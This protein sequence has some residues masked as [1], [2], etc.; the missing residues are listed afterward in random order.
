[1]IKLTV[2]DTIVEVDEGST[3]FQ[4][5]E[6]A[7]VEVP[8]F[9]YHP[10]LS[11]AGNC[12]MCLVEVEKSPKPVASCAMPASEGM[13]VKTKTEMV[14]KAREG[15]LELLLINHPLD[16]P[17]CDQG[18]ECDLQD[19]TVS[20]GRGES[21][22]DLNKR[23]VQDKNMGPLIK[24]IMTRCIHCTRCVR[25]AHE[26]A[27]TDELA[28]VNRGE[29][30]EITSL[31]ESAVTSELSGNLVD[32]C[33]VGA[34]TNKPYAFHGR[35]WELTKTPT[36]DVMDGVGS[37]I[38]L[39]TRG[40][41]EVM[42][43]LPRDCDDVNEDWISDRTRF[44]YD[45]LKYQRLDKPYLR[46]KNKLMPATWG[47]AFTSVAHLLSKHKSNE[48]AVLAGPLAD[49]DGL[50]A[51]KKLMQ[52]MGVE[53]FECRTQGSKLVPQTRQ[54]YLFNTTIA[55]IEQADICLLI[56]TNPRVDATL[57]NARLRKQYL[58]NALHVGLVGEAA[59][60][61]YPYV[62]LGDKPVDIE[63]LRDPKHP[64][65]MSLTKASNP[66]IILG[67]AVL[68]HPD[69]D[70]ILALV[71][72]FAVSHGAIRKDWNGFNI[73]H[74]Q[75]GT[76]GALDLG[77]LPKNPEHDIESLYG[78]VEAGR[79]KILYLYG[80]DDIDF[81]RLKKATIIYQGH[82]GDLGAHH[83]HVILPG[84]A[85]SEKTALYVN[86]EGRVQQ[87]VQAVTT[88]GDAKEDWRIVRSL[89][90]YLTKPLPF[91]TH[92]DLLAKL[93]AEYP[94]FRVKGEML[95]NSTYSPKVEARLAKAKLSNR[96]LQNALQDVY[97]TNV[98]ARHSKIL[99]ECSRTKAVSASSKKAVKSAGGKR[100]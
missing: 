9:C 16:C 58:H 37:H 64:M 27:G 67:E 56:G 44:A 28:A 32:I 10:K 57:V 43:V 84:A 63:F 15:V 31:L 68:S 93:M 26:I 14:K 65:T 20:Y 59:D 60:L 34:L 62:H 90:D 99:A 29:H 83:A 4:A 49:V 21:R 66:M 33:P 82:H 78:D 46:D 5:C 86:I 73:L 13:V 6:K 12:R 25:F 87:A 22:F 23:A 76:T 69:A 48:I 1:M 91:D 40:A 30:M 35:P 38:R 52:S 42:R 8:A 54:D 19:I 70:K 92:Y 80:V 100:D 77:Y 50:Y 36:I 45:G 7:G 95:P 94:I 74:T 61:T 3:V 53:H 81:D 71:K 39:D 85:Y 97:L 2:D 98:I 79:I 55:G 51:L 75:A 96:P 72:D 24:T 89:S 11:I 47:E 88:P 17:I 18:G 41:F